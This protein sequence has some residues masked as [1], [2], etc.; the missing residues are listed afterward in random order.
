[1]LLFLFCVLLLSAALA[2]A[3]GSPTV[4]PPPWPNLTFQNV[5]NNFSIDETPLTSEN[6]KNKFLYP[7]KILL[8]PKKIASRPT[9]PV[10]RGRG[11]NIMGMSPNTFHALSSPLASP[12]SLALLLSLNATEKHCRKRPLM[13]LWARFQH[14]ATLRKPILKN[15]LCPTR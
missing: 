1:M 11:N 8:Y 15:D 9:D 3:F 5:K 13:K 2:A 12:A 10:P 14:W 7:E 4:E 6:V